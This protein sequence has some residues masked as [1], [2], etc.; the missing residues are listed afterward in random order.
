MK[1]KTAKNKDVVITGQYLGVVEEFLPDD[2]STYVKDGEIFATK[3]GMISINDKRKIEIETHQ[4]VD[5][6]TVKIGDIVLGPILFLR[7]YSVGL[8][9]YTINQKIHFNSSYLGNIH[10]SQISNKYVE[11]VQDAFQI[12]DIV[13]AK[14][15]DQNANEFTL[16]TVGKNLGVIHG[17]CSICGTKLEK[18]GFNKLKCPLCLNVEK[19]KLAD[20]Y[21]NVAE[22]LR[23]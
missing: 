18:I 17:D 16:T 23:F 9:F 10:V 5:R 11:K 1:K 3:T 2:Q 6:K 21:G 14:V 22:N 15:I 12:T 13:R 4:D 20:D 7:K 8:N 19:R